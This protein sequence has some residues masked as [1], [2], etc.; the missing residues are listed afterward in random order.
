M[1]ALEEIFEEGVIA[2]TAGDCHN[3]YQHGTPEANA[4]DNGW[5][6]GEAMDSLTGINGKA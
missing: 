6:E 4:W 3:P 5:W 1:D 2:Y